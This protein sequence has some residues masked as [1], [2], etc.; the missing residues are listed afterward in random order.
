MVMTRIALVL[1]ACLFAPGLLA[2]ESIVGKV[3]P[4]FAANA[5]VNDT[6]Y[7]TLAS[8]E[9]DVVVVRIY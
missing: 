9:G 8:C 4:E 3:A 1:L 5:T 6:D 2:Q 7:R